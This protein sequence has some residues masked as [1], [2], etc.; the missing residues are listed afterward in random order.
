[1][2][3]DGIDQGGI[4][5]PE[6]AVPLATFTGWNL[7][8]E[9]IGAPQELYSMQGS[10]IPFPKTK[11][12]RTEKHDPRQSIEERYI[13]KQDFIDKVTA[14]ANELVKSGYLLKQDV[15]KVVERS[16]AEWDYLTKP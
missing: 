3:Q 8:S 12:E 16:V 4:K 13:S 1:M 9:K 5:M 11:T 14:S 2:D 15:P 10:F 7:R 6:V